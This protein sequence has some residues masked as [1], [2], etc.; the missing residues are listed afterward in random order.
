MLAC[1]RHL[2][3]AGIS[4]RLTVAG[5]LQW[6]NAAAEVDAEVKRLGLEKLVELRP[7]FDQDEA[8]GIYQS[9][10]ILL[11]PKYLDPCPTVVAKALACG[12][13]VV[14]SRSGGLP[15]MTD[16]GCAR[17]IEAPLVWDR[18]VTASGE[19]LASAVQ[20][21][22]PRLPKHPPR[23]VAAPKQISMPPGGL[24][25]TGKFLPGSC[26][27]YSAGQRAHSR[28]QRRDLAR[29]VDPQSRRPNLPQL[30]AHRGL[31]ASTYGTREVIE[32]LCRRDPRS[33]WWPTS[34]T[35]S[36][37]P[38]S[39]KGFRFAAVFGSH[40]RADDISA[41]QRLRSR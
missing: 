22:V 28:L 38:V 32:A 36:K 12:L 29:G 20:E 41:P 18:L 6:R 5:P 15:E 2:R 1:A 7:P 14:A 33:A 30:G 19:E 40:V 24:T 21:I 23:R 27:E 3:D 8:V 10:H 17:L 9:H 39:T 31:R 4:C 26:R 37:R 13:P 25:G 16:D 35:K 11:H 34:C